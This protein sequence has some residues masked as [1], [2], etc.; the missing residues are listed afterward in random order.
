MFMPRDV[1]RGG[2]DVTRTKKSYLRWLL[3][4]IYVSRFTGKVME[5]VNL[6]G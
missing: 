4:T 6:G 2:I 1:L 3:D 5:N